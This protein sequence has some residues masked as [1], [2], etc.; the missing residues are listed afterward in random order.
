MSS[1][2][3]LFRGRHAKSAA[4]P[5]A[6]LL[7]AITAAVL[8]ACGGSAEPE[9][10][11][12]TSADADPVR[13]ASVPTTFPTGATIPAD[14][15]IKGMFGPVSPWP[16]IAV[17]AVLMPD[18][19]VMS[20]G[21][22][23]NGKQT[24]YFIYDVW[25]PA[26]GLSGGHLT[27]PNT[28]LTDIFCGSQIVLPEGGAVFL[29]GGDNWTGTGTTNTGNNNSNVFDYSANTLTRGNNMNRARWYSS[30]TALLNGEIY[31][32]GGTGGTDRP[33]IRG[34]DGTFRVLS[35]A[36]TSTFDFMY[37]RNFIAPDGRVF[38]YDSGGKMF[39]VDTS[40]SGTITNVG[41]FTGPRGNDAS[42]AMFVPGKILQFG[43]TSNGAVVIDIT[44]GT[45]VVTPTQSMTLQRRLANA[46]IM[47]DG[48]VVATGGSRVWNTLTDVSYT[49]D[50]WNPATG[51]WTTGATAVQARLYHSNALLMPD[52]T[53]L[54][55]GGGAP[56]PQNNRNV[57]V[58][59]PPYLFT[60]D[61]QLAPRPA[62][63]AA[64]AVV[65]IGK[66]FS[67]DTA[68]AGTPT[69]VVM[70]KTGSATHSFNMSQR[71][72]E[73]NFNPSA[74]A[75]R[76]YVQAPTKAANAPPG[77]YLLFVLNENGVPSVAQMV[78]V[79]VAA[80]PNPAFVP[81]L[82]SPG[83]QS[84]AAGV[85]VQFT[86]NGV[87]PNNDTLI[88]SA[89]GLPP[90]M[91][92]NSAT[93]QISGVP[94]QAGTYSVTVSAS[95]GV[96]TASQSFTWTVT[97]ADP[98]TLN[99]L[100]N[101]NPILSGTT[102]Q[103]TASVTNGVNPMFKWS[104]G[105]GSPETAYS[106][107]ADVM[108]TYSR[109][110][111]F[112]V[113]VTATDVR[114]IE[115]RKSFL[116]AV[117]L[118]ATASQP[119][120]SSLMSFDQSAGGNPRLWMVNQDNDSVSVFD[121][122]TRVKLAEITVG[123]A[124]RA[125]ARAGNGMM[126]VTNRITRNIS[127][128]DPATLAVSRTIS[129]PRGSQ[130]YGVAMT[131]DGTQAF[132]TLG[133][134]G[135]LRRYNT[136]TYALAGEIAVGPNPRHVS[137]T[138][139][140]ASV[141]VSR[142]ITP[143]LPGEATANVQTEIEGVKYGG[144]V[145]TVANTSTM[146]I[147]R[148]TVLAH[149]D[150]EDFENQGRGVP[151]YLGTAAISPDG[152]QAWLPSKQDNIKRGALRDSTGLNFQSTV[153]AISSR[154]DMATGREDHAARIDHDNASVA[155]AAAY[156][157][158]GVYLFVALET[159]RE[160]AVIDAHQKVELIR[161]DV[162]RAPQALAV[163]GDRLYVGNFM[164]RSVS[165]FDLAPLLAQG[166]LSLPL[167]GTWTSVGTERLTAQVLLGKQ[168]FYDARDPRLARDRYMSCATCHN[169][170]FHD[171]R[172]WDLTGFGEGLRN[173][174]SLRGRAAGHG[175]LHW[176]NNFDEL[177]DF[178]GQIRALSGGT[179]LMSDTAFNTGTRNQ[180]LGDR[181]AGQSAELDALAAYVASL[182]RFDDSPHR[183]SNNTLTAD[184][185]TGKTLFTN[186]GCGTCHAG[187]AF[188][189][190]GSNTWV[191]VGTL[192]PS[193]GGR[194]GGTLGGIDVPTLRDVWA[195]APYL[196]DGSAPTLTDAI[197]SH[198]HPSFNGANV[199]DTDMPLLVAYVQQ[200]GREEPSAPVIA[201]TGTGL[202]GSYT[203][204]LTMSGAPV[205]ERFERIDY[206]WGNGAPGTGVNSNTFS[207]R[208]LGRVEAPVTG[209][210]RFQT[211]SDEGVRLWVNGQLIINNWTNHGATT[212]TSAGINLVAGQAYEI[213]LEYY[214]NTGQ[215]VIRL[216]WQTPGTTTYPAIPMDRLYP[217]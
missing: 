89:N 192:K 195:T 215:S 150:K 86:L 154:I 37:P 183:A 216:R 48:K 214:E 137:V 134:T 82:A 8:T 129:L 92:I 140:G 111:V 23:G 158:R 144:E 10:T 209:T 199:S 38:G 165:V 20:Y 55:M 166:Q 109:P 189:G 21:T 119:T 142:F 50:I 68:G 162:G 88:Y 74:T 79:P 83:N 91:S 122:V 102:I 149:S 117:Y 212:D 54:V 206:N 178:E 181:K 136:A 121:T 184:A 80:D 208:W 116:Q 76:Y 101:P 64:P 120:G 172:V 35:N 147:A 77:H 13:R 28:T 24:G 200:I 53:V 34:I 66:T 65:D 78:R 182:N 1:V 217:N 161:I 15:H 30:S 170:G 141:L 84:G 191:D 118:P 180:P 185:V 196:H 176:S 40:G 6:W 159:S 14:A 151:N 95:D 127:V 175:F 133:A 173:T 148:T 177:Q 210:Y 186:L 17:H 22:D 124:P 62:I 97:A 155:S 128:I 81:T 213:K 135:M 67:I 197:R 72:V 75:G 113:T 153:R 71:F 46:T 43:G 146:S 29:A 26:S 60:A 12:T 110:G 25:D 164:D 98:L 94:T 27:L 69:R 19:R 138:A 115:Q 58:Y 41:T 156:D 104:F 7:C 194:L 11:A 205:L 100:P 112:V 57:E 202:F 187:T 190:S 204:N 5:A 107:T 90:G 125:I 61:A 96:N 126:W 132:V 36:N 160:V 114:G 103:L 42:A 167:A 207:V 193:S 152:T 157:P 4:Q 2:N 70:I 39:Y 73:L 168:L 145:V 139:D 171:G 99:P 203:N 211:V 56:G 130:P 131:P 123:T 105:D 85:A 32:Q 63:T 179:G 143:L 16:L 51:T 201:G 174:A 33:E 45:P 31:I 59:F 47:A 87:D 163:A 44:G 169:D 3:A 188:T 108:H 49:A 198:N 18:G 9:T 93:G 106:S 52:A